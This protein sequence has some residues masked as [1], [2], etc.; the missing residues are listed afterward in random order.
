MRTCRVVP[1]VGIRR[2]RKT[3]GNGSTRLSTFRGGLGDHG[4]QLFGDAAATFLLEVFDIFREE[5][6]KQAIAGDLKGRQLLLGGSI[7][8]ERQ[9]RAL[10]KLVERVRRISPEEPDLGWLLEGS[11]QTGEVPI[12]VGNQAGNLGAV[13]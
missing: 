3:G 1:L 2:I 4:F 12:G 6:P 5:G 13:L 9:D 11:G 8:V 10:V 7:R